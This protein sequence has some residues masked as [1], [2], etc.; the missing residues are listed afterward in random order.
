MRRVTESHNVIF[1]ET[2]VSTLIDPYT[3]NNNDD[4]GDPQE[5]SSS[6]G[7]TAD[8][9]ITDHD[10]VPRLLR[11]CWTLPPRISTSQLARRRRHLE[12][13]L[14]QKQETEMME[15]FLLLQLEEHQGI[16]ILGQVQTD[17][18]L[19]QKTL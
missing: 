2:S 11:N 14:R 15:V 5:D 6:S 17:L 10:E 7:N 4:A 16:L 12:T 3:S 8:I 9:S 1:I 19:R 18:L 13:A